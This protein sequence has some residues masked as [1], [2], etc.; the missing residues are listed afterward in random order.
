MN[1]S[2]SSSLLQVTELV[3]L[4]IVL[5]MIERCGG[6]CCDLRIEE[7]CRELDCRMFDE[8]RFVLDSLSVELIVVFFSK[9]ILLKLATFEP[10]V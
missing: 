7:F 4:T 10:G 8:P 5:C 6:Y 2:I 1:A 3:S 9:D